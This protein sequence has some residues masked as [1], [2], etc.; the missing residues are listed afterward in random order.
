[1]NAFHANKDKKDDLSGLE[2]SL[3]DIFLNLLTESVGERGRDAFLQRFERGERVTSVRL[4]PAKCF[5]ENQNFDFEGELKRVTWADN[6]YYLGERPKFT[7]QP[8]FHAGV[9]Y[10]Q[11][12]SGMYMDMIK[13]GIEGVVSDFFLNKVTALDLCAAPGGK[14]THLSSLL[15]D[16]SLLVA[17]EVIR[18]RSVILAD[19]V[20]KWGKG[21]VIVSNNDPADFDK[22]E[23]FF[24]LIVVD[25]PCSGEG[26]F[27]KDSDAINEWSMDNVKL[28]YQRQQR[29]LNDIWSSLK[30]GGFLVYSTCTYNHFENDDNLKYIAQELGAEVIKI[31]Y[32]DNSGIIETA[33]GGLQFI[34]GLVEGEGQFVSLLRKSGD[35]SKLFERRFFSKKEKG[36]GSGGGVV[37]KIAGLERDFIFELAGDLIKGYPKDLHPCIKYIEKSLRVILSGVAVANQK[38]KDLIPHPDFALWSGFLEMVKRGEELPMGVKIVAVEKDLALRFLARDA[39]AFDGADKGYLVLV[40]EGVPLGFVKNL[41]NRSNNLWAVAR[42]IRG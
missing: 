22:L 15:N 25:A 11:E 27:V 1:M 8:L 39:V 19:N 16:D 12:A 31:P 13:A 18:A 38:G 35:D 7:Y 24:D 34:P 32:P 3:P 2:L 10:V 17:N 29:I 20:A 5:D 42:R 26:L 36:K 30:E 40:Y 14:A 21:N 9:Y 33:G 28:C 41:G 37:P 23:E 6:G 4:N